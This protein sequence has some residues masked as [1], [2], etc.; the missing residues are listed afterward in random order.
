[1]SRY[2]KMSVVC[3]L[4]E[5]IHFCPKIKLYFSVSSLSNYE[6]IVRFCLPDQFDY[7]VVFRY[8]VLEVLKQL[9][10]H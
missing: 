4:L 8:C 6:F 10:V 3:V 1:M 2:K 5:V 7:C 9:T